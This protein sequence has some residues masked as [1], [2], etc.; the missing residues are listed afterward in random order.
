[1]SLVLRRPALTAFALLV[2]ALLPSSARAQDAATCSVDLFKPTQLA[3][4]T[5]LIQRAA[6]APEGQ[7]AASAL[8]DAM[9][10]LQD[11]RRFASNTLGLAFARAQI[12]ILWLH[13]EEEPREQMTPSELNAGR[14]RT[15]QIDLAASA[16]SLLTVVEAAAPECATDIDRWRQSKPWSDR[17]GTAYNFLEANQLDSAELYA[18]KAF[19]LDRRSPFIYNAFAQIAARRGDG[20]AL[21][22][23]LEKAIMLADRDTAL[24]ET[25]RQLRTQY[26]TSLQEAAMNSTDV[27]ERNRMLGTAAR[28]FLRIGQEAPEDPNGPAFISASLDIAMLVQDTTLLREVLSP[29][30]EDPTPYQD[31]ALLIGAETSRML[32][33]TDDAM[34]LY[35]AAL[36]KNPNIRDAN[37]FLAFLLIEAKQHQ[38]AL[39]LTDKLLELDPSNPDNLMMKTLAKRPIAEAET[40]ATKRAALIRELEAL[41]RQEA[42]MAQQLRITRFERRAEGAILTGEIEN[43]SRAA[44]TYTVN[45]EFLDLDGN[46]VES[47]SVTT[48]SAAPSTSVTFEVN[49]TRPGIAA[50]RYAPLQ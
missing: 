12:Y 43:R 24:V 44:K 8:R 46:V 37:Y 26:A 3:Q 18:Q 15:T 31:L 29:M 7:P 27:A 14:D 45:V 41:T 20:D 28:T 23:N 17:I 4:A 5:V 1:M 35:R 42:A 30:L 32:N 40:D 47:V 48:A 9:R 50:Y 34:S 13:Q 22:T 49:A 11:D 2:A 25:T 16:D 21:R 38:E 33:R 39:P 6:E 10:L 19:Q 36:A